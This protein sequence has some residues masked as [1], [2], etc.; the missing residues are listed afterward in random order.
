MERAIFLVNSAPHGE[1]YTFSQY[2]EFLEQV[3]FT[4]VTLHGDRPV[5]AK[6]DK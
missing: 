1:F 5:S 3:G 6:K 4:Q 2:Q